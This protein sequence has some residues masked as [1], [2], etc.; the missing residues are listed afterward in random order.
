MGSPSLATLTMS[1]I[2]D[3]VLILGFRRQIL[4]GKSR[5]FRDDARAGGL[6]LVDLLECILSLPDML[7][8]IITQ[9]AR[10]LQNVPCDRT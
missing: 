3:P 5:E 10:E 1:S 6:P 4:Y 7:T 9:R 8:T 2:A